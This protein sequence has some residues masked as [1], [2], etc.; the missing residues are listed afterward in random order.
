MCGCRAI[1]SAFMFVGIRNEQLGSVHGLH[2]ANFLLDQVS[3]PPHTPR[4]PPRAPGHTSNASC[5]RPLCLHLS[6]SC[7]ASNIV[8]QCSTLRKEDGTLTCL[9]FYKSVQLLSKV[10]VALSVISLLLRYANRIITIVNVF[11]FETGCRRASIRLSCSAGS[12]E[13]RGSIACGTGE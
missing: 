8:I 7:K 2:N 13:D 6:D 11:A 10:N 1:P 12:I 3:S 5:V 9:P 4:P